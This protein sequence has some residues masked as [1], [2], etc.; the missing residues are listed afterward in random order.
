MAVVVA[1]SYPWS[2]YRFISSPSLS[3]RVV[4]WLLCEFIRSYSRNRKE[5]QEWVL[6]FK[7]AICNVDITEHFL[8]TRVWNTGKVKCY[9]KE[10]KTQRHEQRQK[11]T[12]MIPHCYEPNVKTNAYSWVSWSGQ[13][14]ITE[15][16]RR[17]GLN[18]KHFSQFWRP[19]SPRSRRCW[20]I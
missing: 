1:S 2:Q 3:R 4:L 9:G 11:L 16:C 18:N 6:S 10:P 13:A 20:Q 14:D 17:G 15:H 19:E 5:I 7:F 8:F 12:Q